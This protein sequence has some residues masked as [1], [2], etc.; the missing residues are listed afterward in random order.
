MS[1]ELSMEETILRSVKAILTKVVRETAVEPGMLHPLSAD[2]LDDIRNCFILI[3]KRERE[4]AAAAGRPMTE[5]PRFKDE[6]R[7]TE[8]VVI[9]LSAIRR[10]RQGREN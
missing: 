2:T 6:P 10:S 1:T 8:D 7:P 9:P 3:T 5:R 4:L